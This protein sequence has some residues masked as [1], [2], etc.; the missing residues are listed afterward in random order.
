MDS[1]EVPFLPGEETKYDS[2]G[3]VVEMRPVCVGIKELFELRNDDTALSEKYDNDSVLTNRDDGVS[4][5]FSD[6]DEVSPMVTSVDIEEP[7][8]DGIP[9]VVP[10]LVNVPPA[11]S[12]KVSTSELVLVST[13]DDPDKWIESEDI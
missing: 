6:P 4:M 2:V 3:I 9:L 1:D 5:M 11:K 13:Y 7:D 12:V 8:V 10:V